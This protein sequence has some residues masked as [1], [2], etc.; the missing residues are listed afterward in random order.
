MGWKPFQKPNALFICQLGDF[1][2]C[3][4]FSAKAPLGLRGLLLL[5]H[6]LTYP[7]SRGPLIFLGKWDLS[8]KI[9]T[10]LG[11]SK[12]HRSSANKVSL[13]TSSNF[14]LAKN[15]LF[16]HLWCKHNNFLILYVASVL[17]SVQKESE[18]ISNAWSY[19]TNYEITYLVQ[20]TS[21]QWE[22]K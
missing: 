11:R 20:S 21:S 14:L 2:P 10:Y 16:S 19:L 8:R 9:G 18:F 15:S 1:V 17:R 3:D 12:G 7:A 13:T 22:M 5:V 4:C 6:S